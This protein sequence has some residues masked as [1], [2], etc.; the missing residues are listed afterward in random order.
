M[1][2]AFLGLGAM[3]EPMA[4]RIALQHSL[5]VWNRTS[6]VAEALAS[7]CGCVAAKTPRE[8]VLDADVAL[9]CLPTS[10]VVESLLDGDQGI[11][12]GLKRGA[13]LLD[14]TSGSPAGSRRIA[15]RLAALGVKY[16]DCPVSGGVTG[17][18]KGTLTVMAGGSAETLIQGDP[19]LRCFAKKI[20]HLG[21][22]GA[23][24][25]MKAVNNALYAVALQA[26]S[27]GATAL[28][29]FGVAP[30]LAVEAL[31]GSSGRSYLSEGPVPE[32]V[33][34]GAF[35][36]TFKLALLVKDVGIAAELL[37]ETGVE[38]PLMLRAH[39]AMRAALEQAA[40]DADFLEVI[41]LAERR[42]GVELRNKK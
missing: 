4:S 20:V 27:E 12:Q 15:E 13:V 28:A 22:V 6:A 33:L 14:C 36:P 11:A 24:C 8:A 32:R 31:N 19:V 9:T 1:R 38:A 26:F 29:K 30:D 16:A 21:P 34:T 41:R 23:G 2:V 35:T 17:A 18:R 40:P 7:R 39:E 25:A 3:G 37:R 5:I 10:Q 42:E